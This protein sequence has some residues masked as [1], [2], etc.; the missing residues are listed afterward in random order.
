MTINW[1]SW[2]FCIEIVKMKMVLTTAAMM[3]DADDVNDDDYDV[4]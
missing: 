1:A 2:Y 4:T 3:H